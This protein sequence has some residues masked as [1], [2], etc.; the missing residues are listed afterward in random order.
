MFLS[1]QSGL[2]AV[3]LLVGVGSSFAQDRIMF[4]AESSLIIEGTSNQSD[5]S[6]TADSLKGWMEL[7][8]DTDGV[9]SIHG[10]EL[11]VTVEEMSGGRGPIMDRLMLRSLKATEHKEII[12]EFLGADPTQVYAAA[13]DSFSVVT[14]GILTIAGETREI[15]M[16][17]GVRQ[18]GTGALVFGGSHAMKMSEFEME[19][20]TAMFGALRTKD[21]IVIHFEMVVEQD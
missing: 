2:V 12:Y 3:F 18:S 7:S 21:D 19:P 15:E 6:V 20:P 8:I 14:R 1:R 4:G 16:V 10:V 17:V 5:W 9:P 11:S 13:P